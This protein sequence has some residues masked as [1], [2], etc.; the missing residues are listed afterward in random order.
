MDSPTS[1][2]P[3]TNPAAEGLRLLAA[4]QWSQAAD[5]LRTAR[6][7]EPGSLSVVRALATALLQ[8]G[9]EPAARGALSDFT[10]HSPMCAEGW[11]L[12][13]QLEWK[14]NRYDRAMSVLARGLERLPNSAALHRQRSLFWGARGQLEGAPRHEPQTPATADTLDQLVADSKLLASVLDL[15]DDASDTEMLRVVERKLAALLTEQPRHADR[16]FLLARLRLKI[17]DL[18]GAMFSVR[19]AL[20]ANPHYTQALRL[21]ATILGQIGEFDEAIEILEGLVR[22][23]TDWPDLHDQVNELKRSARSTSVGLASRRA[24]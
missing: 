23:G 1:Q 7:R 24:A 10:I 3:T 13:A 2:Q 5:L 22:R 11:R 21:Q 6:R 14:L 9:D 8:L 18:V 4:G 15:P 19:R 17:G 16:Q 20:R 12:A